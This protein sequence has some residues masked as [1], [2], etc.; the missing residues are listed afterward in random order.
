VSIVTHDLYVAVD[1]MEKAVKEAEDYL[2]EG[3]VQM[4]V[5]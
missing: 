2:K 5:L 1:S 4:P 3:K